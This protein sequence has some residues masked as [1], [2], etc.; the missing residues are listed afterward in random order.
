[1][2]CHR[3]PPRLF[4]TPLLSTHT[5]FWHLLT[6]Q[7]SLHWIFSH[8]FPKNF[9]AF[10]LFVCTN[11]VHFHFDLHLSYSEKSNFP[12][13]HFFLLTSFSRSS[14]HHAVLLFPQP[15]LTNAKLHLP[16]ISLR[17]CRYCWVW[18]VL[19]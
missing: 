5:S 4:Y 2:L 9:F 16:F 13:K 6:S 19:G 17:K 18:L 1:M 3:Q 11:L 15:I 12:T 10:P 14:L 8:H 7:N